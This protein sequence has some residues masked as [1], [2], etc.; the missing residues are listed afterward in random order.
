MGVKS[1]AERESVIAPMRDG[2]VTLH[3][4]V[5]G[6]LAAVETS[7]TQ[8]ISGSLSSILPPCAL[9]TIRKDSHGS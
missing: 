1:L 4:E 2:L 7:V 6:D 3:L 8:M 9:H 5:P